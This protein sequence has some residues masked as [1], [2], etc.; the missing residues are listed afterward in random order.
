MIADPS[1]DFPRGIFHSRGGLFCYRHK[2]KLDKNS[3]KAENK[4]NG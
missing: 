2:R 1:G 4:A 3:G